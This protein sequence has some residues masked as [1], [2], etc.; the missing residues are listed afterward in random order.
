MKSQLN[1][2][3]LEDDP[4]DAALIRS[5]LEAEGI[6]CAI[7]RVENREDF[8]GT[9]EQGGFGLILSDYSLPNFD[10]RSALKT[11]QTLQPRVPFIHVPAT[12]LQRGRDALRGHP[13]SGNQAETDQEVKSG[14]DG[15]WKAGGPQ[16]GK[17]RATALTDKSLAVF[18]LR[19]FFSQRVSMCSAWRFLF[20]A[21]IIVFRHGFVLAVSCSTQLRFH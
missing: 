21:G 4:R 18:A 10:G 3:R 9:L 6:A 11:A 8:I 20:A 13:S 2:L 5:T 12:R 14:C 15:F 16:R 7:T 19:P 17:A 1:I